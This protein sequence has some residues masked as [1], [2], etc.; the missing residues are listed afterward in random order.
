MNIVKQ[1]HDDLVTAVAKQY[2]Q[3]G[4]T[5]YK[6]SRTFELPFDLGNYFPDIVAIRS[7]NEGVIIEIKDQ[8]A[9]TSVDRFR[10]ISEMVA[11]H[12]GW[13][14]LL[15][16]GDADSPEVGSSFANQNTLTW[17]Q[18]ITRKQKGERLLALGE[19]EGAFVIL[20]GTLEAILRKR[21][22]QTAIPIERFPVSSLIKHL[23]SQGELAM[24]HFDTA[25]DL[26]AVRNQVMHG[27]ETEA[28]E[29]THTAVVLQTLIDELLALWLPRELAEANYLGEKTPTA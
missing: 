11:Q 26:L 14:F 20:W 21:A 18:I 4:Y 2:E 7:E 15:V 13:R 25:L 24:M 29:L 3:D 28:D 1:K 22:E 5:V 19:V 6:N 10:T 17:E 27:F 16:T 23:Y 9:Q 12:A 8:A